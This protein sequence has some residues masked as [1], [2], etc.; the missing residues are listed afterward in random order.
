MQNCKKNKSEKK[1]THGHQ[2]KFNKI[3][4]AQSINNKNYIILKKKRIK[5]NKK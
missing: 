5:K 2:K 3:S 4:R 1:E